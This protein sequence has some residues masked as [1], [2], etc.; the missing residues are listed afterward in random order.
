MYIAWIMIELIF[1]ELF[2]SKIKNFI[3]LQEFTSCLYCLS[4]L[5]QLPI[6]RSK[7]MWFHWMVWFVLRWAK[8][9]IEL[10]TCGTW[11]PVY[12]LDRKMRYVIHLLALEEVTYPSKVRKREKSWIIFEIYFKGNSWLIYILGVISL[13]QT[14]PG[15]VFGQLEIT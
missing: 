9:E 6:T 5:R 15:Q 7:K 4:A 10:C 1:F 8:Q 12:L 13:G 2:I 14:Q 11:V 3:P